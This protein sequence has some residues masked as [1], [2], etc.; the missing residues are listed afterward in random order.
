MQWDCGGIMSQI[1]VKPGEPESCLPSAE[2]RLLGQINRG[3][4]DAWWQRYHKLIEKRQKAVLR[5]AEH[6]ELIK[7]TDEVE[8]REA[9][10]LRALV[11]LAKLR[12]QSLRDL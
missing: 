1:R 3:F 7:L 6:R 11:K 8:R 4:A 9:N 2:A 10:R 5:A 12:K